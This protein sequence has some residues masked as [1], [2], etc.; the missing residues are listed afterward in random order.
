MES[1]MILIV[2]I[3]LL[4]GGSGGYLIRGEAKEPQRVSAEQLVKDAQIASKLCHDNDATL[5]R[6]WY[7]DNFN[8]HIRCT[9]KD[10]K[11]S[12]E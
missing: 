7:D 2:L 11:R 8:L 3:S 12:Q 5:D 10:Y 9:A 6:V 4:V 1:G